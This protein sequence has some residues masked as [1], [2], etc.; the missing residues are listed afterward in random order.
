MPV[1]TVTINAE[2]AVRIIPAEPVEGVGSV[3]A[4]LQETGYCLVSVFSSNV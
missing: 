4:Q 1:E 3:T 2:C